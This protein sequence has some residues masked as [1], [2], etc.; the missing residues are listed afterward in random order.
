MKKEMCGKVGDGVCVCW[1]VYVGIELSGNEWAWVAK[2]GD[3]VGM[4]RSERE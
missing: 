3:A 2:S 1:G 4:R